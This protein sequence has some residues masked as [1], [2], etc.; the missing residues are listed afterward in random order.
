VF[1]LFT[2]VLVASPFGSYLAVFVSFF[3]QVGAD[4]LL[5]RSMALAFFFIHVAGVTGGS[6]QADYE[7]KDSHYYFMTCILESTRIYVF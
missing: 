5:F 6:S 2:D 7:M 1:Y 4:A 3:Y